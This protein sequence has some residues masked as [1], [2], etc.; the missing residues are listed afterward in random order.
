[1]S[2]SVTVATRGQVGR[3]DVSAGSGRRGA[4]SGQLGEKKNSDP[5][6]VV[7]GRLGERTGVHGRGDDGGADADIASQLGREV[8]LCVFGTVC[9]Q[10]RGTR[11]GRRE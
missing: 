10:A 7:T 2:D 9:G 4:R 11:E 3:N 8:H 5:S 6:G 1:M